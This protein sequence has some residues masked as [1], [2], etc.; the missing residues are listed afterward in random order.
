[1]LGDTLIGRRHPHAITAERPNEGG[2]AELV[3]RLAAIVRGAPSLIRVLLTMRALDL[4]DWL[5][6]SGAVYQRVLNALTKRPPD[7]SPPIFPKSPPA[8][9]AG[10]R[11]SRWKAQFSKGAPPLRN[12]HV[13]TVSPGSATSG[14]R[15]I[16]RRMRRHVRF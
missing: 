5:I 2:E 6:M 1:M 14:D 10:G 12:Y 8:S 9:P 4:P 7:G 3:A 15:S 11:K 13:E 16:T